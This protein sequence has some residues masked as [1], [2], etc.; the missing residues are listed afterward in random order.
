MTDPWATLTPE[1]RWCRPYHQPP[2][3]NPHEPAT[4]FHNRALPHWGDRRPDTHCNPRCLTCKRTDLKCICDHR[5]IVCD[6]TT[7][8]TLCEDC[9]RPTKTRVSRTGVADICITTTRATAA[10][11]AGVGRDLLMVNPCPHC[12]AAHAHSSHPAAH[13]YRVAPCGKPYLLETN[14]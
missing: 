10:H 7:P 11:R 9:A 13:P 1:E 3:T 8:E 14:P 6:H 2:N 12:Q 5:A 4:P